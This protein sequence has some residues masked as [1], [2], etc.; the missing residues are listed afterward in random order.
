[1]VIETFLRYSWEALL[2]GWNL[3]SD[4]NGNLEALNP[5]TLRKQI[6]K[7]RHKTKILLQRQAKI[8]SKLNDLSNDYYFN[9][10]NNKHKN[11]NKN[12]KNE[13]DKRESDILFSYLPTGDSAIPADAASETPNEIESEDN[14]DTDARKGFENEF[15]I[16][17]GLID[18]KLKEAITTH[19]SCIVGDFFIGTCWRLQVVTCTTV[20][21]SIAAYV[22]D[23]CTFI[24]FIMLCV[25]SQ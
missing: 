5:K 22:E 8:Y 7:L 12:D 20:I 11:R 4:K 6:K 21:T 2:I 9:T 18:E 19:K 14:D 24:H 15:K 1:M 10:T 25:H 16:N 23:V 17:T 13:N 3:S